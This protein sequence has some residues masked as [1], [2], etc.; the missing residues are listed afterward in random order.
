[1]A[2]PQLTD[3]I[4]YT[5]TP[6]TNTDYAFNWAEVVK[7]VGDGTFDFTINS[8]TTTNDVTVNGDATVAGTLGVTGAL[9]A[10]SFLSGALTGH[11]KIGTFTRNISTASGTQAI[12]GIGFVPTIVLFMGGRGQL[13]RASIGFDDATTAYSFNA[14]VLDNTVDTFNNTQSL[15]V[16]TGLSDSYGG[17]INSM[18]ADG[19]TI[20][21][22]KAGSP[23]GTLTA[24]YLAIR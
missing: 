4:L 12:T 6:L 13:Q 7:Y 5:A 24:M 23:T 14:Y 11:F 22:T 2:V 8:L 20:G 17:K 1:M 18:D 15:H 19:F 9:T 21:W 10:A 3:F 16:F